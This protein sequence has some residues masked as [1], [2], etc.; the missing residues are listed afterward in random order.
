MDNPWVVNAAENGL[1]FLFLLP[2]G[3]QD[4]PNFIFSQTEIDQYWDG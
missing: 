1:G 2:Y 4:R 3:S